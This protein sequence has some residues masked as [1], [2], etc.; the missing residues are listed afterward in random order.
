MVSFL[1]CVYNFEV[2]STLIAKKACMGNAPRF[3][4]KI[5]FPSSRASH[6]FVV[7]AYSFA[8]SYALHL[9]THSRSLRWQFP[10]LERKGMFW[11]VVLP[12]WLVS[13]C[14]LFL[15]IKDHPVH[16]YWM[17][18]PPQGGESPCCLGSQPTPL[19]SHPVDSPQGKGGC[20]P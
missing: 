19:P 1:L 2:V 10:V 8:A 12:C 13:F 17:C 4:S 9:L 15:W 16:L 6:S 14:R 18:H 7:L 3:V 20:G 11:P 5:T